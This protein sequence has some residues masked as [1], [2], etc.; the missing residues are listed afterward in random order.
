MTL[1]VGDR[2]TIKP[3][4]THSRGGCEITK[5]PKVNRRI[6]NVIQSTGR[7]SYL[8]DGNYYYDE[9][10]LDVEQNSSGLYV[11]TKVAMSSDPFKPIG[12]VVLINNKEVVFSAE[13]GRLRV[14]D[15]TYFDKSILDSIYCLAQKPKK[16]LVS[17]TYHRAVKYSFD[18][19]VHTLHFGSRPAAEAFTPSVGRGNTYELGPITEL[20]CEVEVEDDGK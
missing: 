1:K 16:K 12:E 6:E 7:T 10:L 2:V 4:L 17:T 15:L 3:T 13:G 19:N 20:K 9:D 18:D 14:R 11:G 5:R 8:V